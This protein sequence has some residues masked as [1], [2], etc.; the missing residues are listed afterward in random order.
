MAK[1]FWIIP[2][3]SIWTL[4]KIAF[5][6]DQIDDYT[7][8]DHGLAMTGGIISGEAIHLSEEVDHDDP[9]INPGGVCLRLTSKDAGFVDLLDEFGVHDSLIDEAAIDARHFVVGEEG[10]REYRNAARLSVNQLFAYLRSRDP[11][12]AATQ[13]PGFR[14]HINT[15]VEEVGDTVASPFYDPTGPRIQF[16][17]GDLSVDIAAEQIGVVIT[18]ADQMVNPY[19]KAMMHGVATMLMRMVEHADEAAAANRK[20]GGQ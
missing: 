11:L 19:Q 6:V 15:P 7:S 8:I 10:Q 17:F 3:D 16:P 5:F 18:H 1:K 20:T 14:T 13:E 9:V 4:N 12:F 2:V